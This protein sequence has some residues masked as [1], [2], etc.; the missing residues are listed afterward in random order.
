MEAVRPASGYS[1]KMMMMMMMIISA[2]SYGSLIH[3]I[4]NFKD[5]FTIV[6]VLGNDITCF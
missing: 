3:G 6:T 2:A 4:M 1:L 5:K